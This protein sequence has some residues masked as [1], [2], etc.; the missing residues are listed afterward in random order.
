MLTDS[1][2]EN[3]GNWR[4]LRTDNGDEIEYTTVKKLHDAGVPILIGSDM[5]NG[6]TI[7]G[8]TVHAEMELLVEAGMKPIDALRAA[9][10]SPASAYGFTDR[11]R[12]A[13]GTVADLVMVEGKPDKNITD[14]R[15]IVTIWKSGTVHAPVK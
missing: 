15:K 3:L 12:I 13:P 11:G 7:A 6:G 1:E 5:P 14:S 8:A 10:S 4:A 2:I 9:T